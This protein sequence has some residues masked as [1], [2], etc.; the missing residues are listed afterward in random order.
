MASQ[1]IILLMKRWNSSKRLKLKKSLICKLARP[2]QKTQSSIHDIYTN[3]DKI[4]ASFLTAR[5][6]AKVSGTVCDK[7]LL[8]MKKAPKVWV[9]IWKYNL[10]V[11]RFT[12]SQCAC[13][14]VC[15]ILPLPMELQTNFQKSSNKL[16]KNRIRYW[17]LLKKIAC[18]NLNSHSCKISSWL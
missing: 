6:S 1:P 12:I 8:K 5:Q 18:R 4:Q 17:L 13:M 7:I 2:H 15:S 14:N 10:N 3:K 11:I 16:L 9:K